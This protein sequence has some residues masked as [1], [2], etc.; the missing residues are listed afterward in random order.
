MALVLQI[1]SSLLFLAACL[2]TLIK[3]SAQVLYFP[4]LLVM[5]GPEFLGRNFHILEHIDELIHTLRRLGQ[6]IAARFV[7][8]GELTYS[9]LDVLKLALVLLSFRR[10]VLLL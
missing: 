10:D 1:T 6:H 4:I 8:H 7:I 9:A 2:V 3:I 5:D